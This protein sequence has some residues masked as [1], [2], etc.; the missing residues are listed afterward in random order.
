MIVCRGEDP[1][2]VHAVETFQ[3][4]EADGIVSLPIYPNHYR[5]LGYYVKNPAGLSSAA[6]MFIEYTKRIVKQK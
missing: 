1:T 2:F 6:A 4:F 3:M 5:T